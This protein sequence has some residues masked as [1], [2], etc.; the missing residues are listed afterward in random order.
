MSVTQPS[1]ASPA[2]AGQVEAVRRIFQRLLERGGEPSLST[3]S[4]T[5]EFD[6]EDAGTWHLRIDAGVL[7]PPRQPEAGDCVIR[8]SASVFIEIA[9]GR[10]N[11]V[12]AFLQGRMAVEG[13]VALALSFRRLLPVLP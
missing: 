2:Q 5:Y 11:M 8:C 7:S 9:G 10:H 4:G 6:L 1:I 3:T 13:D 12:T